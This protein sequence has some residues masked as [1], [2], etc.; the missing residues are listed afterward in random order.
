MYYSHFVF[1]A[2]QITSIFCLLH[3]VKLSDNCIIDGVTYF[4]SRNAA[5]YD[6]RHTRV[7]VPCEQSNYDIQCWNYTE[8]NST[9]TIMW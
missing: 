4:Q 9:N 3:N 6:I 7:C 8:Y 2:L 5:N 1:L